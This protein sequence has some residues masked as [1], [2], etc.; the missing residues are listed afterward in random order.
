VD[1]A[2][3][4]RWIILVRNDKA[5]GVGRESHRA[6]AAMAA[7]ECEVQSNGRRHVTIDSCSKAVC[8]AGN[9]YSET[10]IATLDHSRKP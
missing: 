8:S 6:R 7:T 9:V 4:N 10:D 1:Q 3:E 2:G 5:R